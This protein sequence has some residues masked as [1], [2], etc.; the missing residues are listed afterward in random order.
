MLN[1]LKKNSTQ[2]VNRKLLRKVKKNWVVVSVVTLGLLGS[3]NV[4]TNQT[5]LP[6]TTTVSADNSDLG[7]FANEDF[8]F[9]SGTSLFQFGAAGTYSGTLSNA[10]IQ[11]PSDLISKDDMN[12]T[13]VRTI[14][15]RNYSDKNNP[16]AAD[17]KTV[18]QNA[19]ELLTRYVTTNN[20]RTALSGEG[21]GPFGLAAND[22]TGTTK[23]SSDG[24]YHF[25]SLAIPTIEGYSNAVDANG[26]AISSVSAGS[27]SIATFDSIPNHKDYGTQWTASH[28]NT[29]NDVYV[30]LKNHQSTVNSNT[31]NL[32]ENIKD[33]LTKT[34][35]RT[36][37]LK[38]PKGENLGSQTLTATFSGSAEYD[39]N[40]NTLGNITWTEDGNAPSYSIPSQITNGNVTYSN[41]DSTSDVTLND[42]SQNNNNVTV[43]YKTS[44]T[45][46][47]ANNAD[48]HES[49]VVKTFK[50]TVHFVD[51]KGHQ[52]KP[53]Q[54][55]T[56]TFTRE[57]DLDE[58]GNF[59]AT[60]NWQ[61]NN[62][63]FAKVDDTVSGYHVVDGTENVAK[64]VKADD[65]DTD[66]SITI[67]YDT[68]EN[69]VPT[70]VNPTPTPTP[71][72]NGDH[73]NGANGSNNNNSNGGFKVPSAVLPSTNGDNS[74]QSVNTKHSQYV[75]GILPSTAKR[76]E[77]FAVPATFLSVTTAS[78]AL[79]FTRSKKNE[80]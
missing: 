78:L 70:P 40:N 43:T 14:H 39:W 17:I 1:N 18:T 12:V 28:H 9:T 80:Q 53:D 10:G 34:V 33:Q 63:T 20:A 69:P 77:K 51:T 75:A 66:S 56:V 27:G 7:I 31:A 5:V 26:N 19:N 29:Q 79:F 21:F 64:T 41:P 42:V 36:V 30:Y 73:G 11:F 59:T 23:A 25:D 37:T 44:K 32:P 46:I 68:D 52:V 35:S 48:G 6:N 62:D 22:G 38:G 15:F 71:N 60:S 24:L 72:N 13:P 8:T 65:T 57:G 49:D 76:T 3:A 58:N 74:G 61:T 16:N 47:N 4:M 55:E 67:T 45:P 50:R 54:V 2:L